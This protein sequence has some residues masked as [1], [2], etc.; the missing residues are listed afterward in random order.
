[1]KIRLTL[2]LFVM[3]LTGCAPRML[4]ASETPIPTEAPIATSTLPSTLTPSPTPEPTVHPTST[5]DAIQRGLENLLPL[6]APCNLAGRYP[7]QW[8]REGWIMVTCKA[9]TPEDGMITKL[10][11]QET[12]QRL[13][14]SFKDEFISLYRPNDPNVSL[15]LQESF[16][17][18][19]WTADKQFAY[20]AVQTSSEETAYNGYDALFRL[21][22]SSGEM[23]PTLSPAVGAATSYAF[24]F[25][26]GGTML[27]YINQK[28]QPLT[29]V[30]VDIVTG[31]ENKF[32]LDAKF[33]QGGALIW[34]PDEKQLVVS[35]LD[36][37]ANGGNSV[38]VFDLEKME[39]EYLVQQSTEIYLPIEWIEGTKIYAESY[40][41]RWVYID[42]ITKEIVLALPPTPTPY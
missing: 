8:P 40:P 31:A 23:Y 1:M 18:I 10:G 39:N 15:L 5:P 24:K 13:A 7:S 38:I 29:V 37:G 12:G 26:P 34:S 14:I 20:L 4:S 3:L 17:P 27:A 41:D 19:P 36:D 33:T 25:S 6:I 42:V 22:V 9:E 21:D 28:V 11:D 16:I 2:I 32:T 35:A 30:L